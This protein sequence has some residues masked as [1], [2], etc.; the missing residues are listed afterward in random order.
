MAV[1]WRLLGGGTY[2]VCGS[3]WDHPEISRNTS[4]TEPHELT[5]QRGS[6][7]F[8]RQLRERERKRERVKRSYLQSRIGFNRKGRI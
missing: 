4:A 2:E 7:P 5:A 6:K 8:E 1:V 3:E